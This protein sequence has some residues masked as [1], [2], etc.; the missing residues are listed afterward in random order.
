MSKLAISNIAW[1]VEQEARVFKILR[2]NGITGIE[3]AP[4]KVWPNWQG[5]TEV[6]VTNLRKRLAQEG[7]SV[8]SL[9][10]ILFGKADILLFG[11]KRS[12]NYKLEEHIKFVA[13]IAAMLGASKLVFGAPLIRDPGK[14]APDEAWNTAIQIFSR[15]G[16]ICSERGVQLCLEAN[17]EAYGCKFITKFVEAAELVR[18]VA[19]VGFG[20]HLDTGCSHIAN[21]PIESFEA[22]VP[23]ID[24]FHASEPNLNSFDITNVDHQR[25]GELLDTTCYKGWISLEM[26]ANGIDDCAH[27]DRACQILCENYGQRPTAIQSSS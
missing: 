12:T 19:S 26:R 1:A 21:E 8:P 24:H 16:Q 10:A 14:L 22:L 20:L 18:C 2:K 25:F 7:F 23:E 4:T 15:L 5:I 17:P 3:I 11:D 13:D 9:Q 6:A 27:I